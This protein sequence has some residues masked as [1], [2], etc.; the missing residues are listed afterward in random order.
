MNSVLPVFV[1]KLYYFLFRLLWCMQLNTMKD[2]SEVL[3]YLLKLFF[4]FNTSIWYYD[5]NDKDNVPD[6]L[7]IKCI[8]YN[9]VFGRE[10]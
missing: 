9:K 2:S 8:K 7:G 10:L 5:D 3:Q 1:M 4:M 6:D